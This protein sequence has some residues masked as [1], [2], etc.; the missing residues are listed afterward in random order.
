ML[1]LIVPIQYEG[2]RHTVAAE[3]RCG[4]D[5]TMEMDAAATVRWRDL[6]HPLWQV[7]EAAC[8]HS[9]GFLKV[10]PEEAWVVAVREQLEWRAEAVRRQLQAHS[11]KS[12]TFSETAPGYWCSLVTPGNKIAVSSGKCC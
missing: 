10:S 3:D 7:R 8:R 11:K 6:V 9:S 12:C 5:K 2:C 4:A 1:H